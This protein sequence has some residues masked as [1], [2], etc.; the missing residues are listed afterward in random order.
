MADFSRVLAGP[1][2]TMLLADL[3]AT[4]IKVEKPEVGD[5]TRSWGPPWTARGSSYFESLNRSKRSLTLDLASESDQQVARELVRRA[6]ILVENFRVGALARYGLDYDSASVINP[7]LVYASVS[8]FGSDEGARL[9]G[10][11]FVVQAAGGLM[12]ITGA[13]D[14]EPTKVGVAMVDVLTGKDA[15]LGILAALRQREVTG[16]GQHIEVNLMSSLLGALTNQLGGFLATGVAPQAMG[17]QHPSIAPYETLRCADG[18]LAVAVGNDTQFGT[19]ADCL[20]LPELPADPRFA[21]NAERVHNRAV[22]VDQLEGVLRTRPAADWQGRLQQA[23]IACS[24]VNDL[25]G[26]VRYADALGLRPVTKPDGSDTPQVRTP[27][28][29]SGSE[30]VPPA[31]PPILGEHTEQVRAWLAATDPAPLP[32]LQ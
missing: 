23:G 1:Y 10:Y 22:L 30:V 19:F 21:T 9:P 14:G 20:G 29:F 13:P 3:G 27:I 7:G 28:D 25:D 31:A 16:R 12:S 5:D 18:L 2:A 6:D 17:N 8:G 24:Q 32:A 4:V 15:A 11:D 26:A